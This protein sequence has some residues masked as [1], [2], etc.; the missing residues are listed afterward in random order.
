[1]NLERKNLTPLRQSRTDF[2][3]KPEHEEEKSKIIEEDLVFKCA[4]TR[5]YKNIQDLQIIQEGITFIDAGNIM[6]KQMTSLRRLDLSFNKLYKIGNLDC[7]KE[8]RELNLSFNV[9]DSI[10]NLNK[11]PNLRTLILDHNRIKQLENLKNLRKL[12]LLSITGN[13]LEDLYV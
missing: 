2:N 4:M 7:L 11:L 3:M 5:E 1:M 9:I 12:E 8:L 10:E 13:L 6:L